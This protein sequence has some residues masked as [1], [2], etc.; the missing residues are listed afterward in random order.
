MKA[1]DEMNMELTAESGERKRVIPAEQPE[2]KAGT[3]MEA[4]SGDDADDGADMYVKFSKPYVFEDDTYDGLDM[5]CLENLT[6]NDLTA[7]EKTFYKQ[8]IVSFN[9][10][11]T[12]TFAK[13]VAWKATELPIEF[14]D[15]LPVK[16]IMQIKKQV[17]N[18]FYN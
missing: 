9:P 5:S 15:Q 16:D 4:D 14:F 10:E 18:F 2:E 3:A 1:A 6:M 17:V 13:I 7:I 12:I 11:T 8:G